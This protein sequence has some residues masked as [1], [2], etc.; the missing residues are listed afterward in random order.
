M[1]EKDDEISIDFGKIKNFFKRKK[2]EKEVDRKPHPEEKNP[3][4]HTD[5]DT[6]TK[7][8][9]T[10]SVEAKQEE[11]KEDD[12]VSIDFGKIKNLFKKKSNAVPQEVKEEKVE[13]QSGTIEKKDD[14]EITIDLSK[15]K[16]FFK[17]KDSK[18][19]EVKAKEDKE[20]DEISIDFS[21]LKNIKN[22][23]KKDSN[24]T[25]KTGESDEELSVDAKKS[26]ISGIPENSDEEFSLDFK[27]IS[28]FLVKRRVLLLL[29]IPIFL[30]I[31]LRIQPAYLPITDQ[32]ATD[33]V[34]NNIKSDIRGQI[35]QQ[36]PNLP[37]QNKNAL[38]ENE[39]QK[40]LQQ[41]KQQIDQQIAATSNFFKSRLQDDTG[42]TYLI[43]I[44]PYFWMRAAKNVLEN[45]HAGDEIRDGFPW[46]NHM[47][48]PVGRGVPPDMFHAYFEAF[49]FKFLSFFNRNLN[50]MT[51]VFFVP[52]LI[53]ALAVIPTF[54]ITRKIVGD[55]GGF[56]AATIIAIH[57]SFLTRTVGGFADTD[58]YNIMFPLFIAWLFLEALEAK[59][60]KTSII[61]SALSG[62]LVGLYA[63]T[64][65]GWWYIFDFI[66]ISVGFYMVYYT[67][68]HRKKLVGNFA[69]FI[70]Q[71]AIKNSIAFLLIF[72]IASALSV[73][74]FVSYGKFTT[75]AKSPLGF[76]KLKEVG[77]TTIWPNVFTTVAE[78]N[79]ASLNNVINQVGLGKFYFFL[80][81][82]MGITLTLTTKG[83]KKLWFVIGSLVWYLIIF[84]LKVQNLNTF[85][86]LISIPIIIRILFALW[87]SDTD[88]DIKY[89]I[90]L[91]LWF[92]ATI[93]AS[94]KGV[95]FT[96]L[97]VPAFAIGFGI[98]LGELYRYAS[99]WISKGLHVNKYISKTTVIVIILLLLVA[100]YRSAASTARSEI[101]SFNDAWATSLEKIKQDS[102]PDA[103]INSWW[104]FGHWFKFW[105][106]RAVTFDGTS[107]NTPPAHWVGKV[108]LTDD[109]EL[110]IGILR[111]LDCG[112]KEG[113][114]TV[115][116]FT[117]DGLES[118]DI[119]YEVM[120]LSRKDARNSLIEKFNEEKAEKILEKTHC[121]PPENYFIT[122]DD[123]IGKSGVWAHFGSW[124]FNRGLIYNT[125]KKK[126][127]SND[128]DKSVEFL[129]QR[130][131]Y[132]KGD[133]ENLF[134]EV[135]SITTS[136]Q[137]N[138]WI[139]PWPGYAG[140]AGCS[141][142][143]NQTI[144]CN[145]AGIPL[146]FNLFTNEAY[147]DSST[148]RLHPKLVSFPTN[149]DIILR[150][151]NE[152]VITLQN[153][154]QL[155][156][157]LI[158][159]GE[160]YRA[161]AMDSDLTGSM[162]TRM[163]YQEGIGLKYFKKFSDERSVFGGRIIVWK[164]DWEGKE[165]NIISVPK[166]EPIE[167]EIE[168]DLNKIN[169]T[170]VININKTE[171]KNTTNETNY[172]G[173]N[174]TENEVEELINGSNTQVDV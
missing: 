89:A 105:A 170:E 4:V 137:A 40:L 1:E 129:Q 161:V 108:L 158:K 149:E 27:K 85:L 86:I 121:E 79:P 160:S 63:F 113:F 94:T 59:N 145:V 82:M 28:N 143:D 144:G 5:K 15:I 84:L 101:P 155:G 140:T 99:S 22:I 124:D 48:A 151:Y 6:E 154:R 3:E 42:Q 114:N 163:Y 21:K 142:I 128:L 174:N 80:I 55:V 150:E 24:E 36:Y 8:E 123:M 173:E 136:S 70:K 139:A 49:L 69:K 53:S 88:I 162:F 112:S 37:D 77:I 67:F 147:A 30:S 32:W 127:Y 156:I 12:E 126:E 167:E 14:D 172:I 159:N 74:L 71:K 122:S 81:A 17:K 96:L 26:K 102:K 11:K 62:L 46:D 13:L 31:F 91:V 52:V 133:A 103:I 107:Q 43:A 35:N 23:F 72:F 138:N 7:H 100:P 110:A 18:S 87:E 38:V 131:D 68:V 60:M 120:P 98:A 168:I 39:F 93:F 92:I 106:D 132:S 75:F 115:S 153:G 16:N 135:Q 118:I 165:K 54:F 19:E 146:T 109:E 73:T 78:Q 83:R 119:M 34:I 47:F 104:D 166:P 125:L 57:P 51:V 116:E 95:R 58:A 33:S 2:E 130:F 25:A 141:N 29:I 50:L 164:V 44:D 10:Q 152:S 90:F 61:L 97:L 64:W 41:Q 9:Q 148:G 65:G 66:L 171:I 45:G 111:M 20:E 76:A 134:Y 169:G 56:I 157:A 117:K